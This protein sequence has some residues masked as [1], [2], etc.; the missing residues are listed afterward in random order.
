MARRGRPISNRTIYRALRARAVAGIPETSAP[1]VVPPAGPSPAPPA[2]PAPVG[3]P[4]REQVQ[5]DE[6]IAKSRTWQR[7]QEA[8]AAALAKHPEAAE[9]VAAALESVS[10]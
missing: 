8:L 2:P 6:L 7:V 4:T 10:L 5:V 9:D 1:P 3:A